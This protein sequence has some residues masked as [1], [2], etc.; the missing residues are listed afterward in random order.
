MPND[1]QTILTQGSSS[2]TGATANNGRVV[3]ASQTNRPTAAA[4]PLLD[5]LTARLTQQ[6]K[7]ITSS[8]TSNLQTSMNDAIAST[9]LGGDLRYQQLESERSR[10]MGFARDRAGATYTG[11]LESRTGYATQVAGL[12]ELT[13][14][15]EKSIRDLDKRYQEAILANDSAT[16]TRVAD[17]QVKKLEFQQK[18]EENFF[19]NLMG[20]ANMQEQA[21]SRAQQNEQFWQKSEQDQQQF[22]MN[23]A[24]S[25]V[26]F[27]KNYGLN[28]KEMG[29][30]EQQLELERSKYN[31]SV[32]EY[33]DRKKAL[34]NDKNSMN[35]QAMIA[36]DIKTKLQAGGFDKQT[37]LTPD[38]IQFVQDRT[39]F[40]GSTE[41]L[42]TLITSA[43]GSVSMDTG[44]MNSLNSP[45][46]TTPSSTTG[47]SRDW[48]RIS[49][50]LGNMDQESWSLNPFGNTLKMTSMATKG[51]YNY[52]TNPI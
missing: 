4:N 13:E 33:N 24:N 27:E 37:L 28:L 25:N 45:A 9:Q 30:K 15:T 6:A 14:T 51:T 29:L 34:I 50:R 35:T 46:S 11:A 49:N 3:A 22:V 38:Y 40:K 32:S 23:M 5:A 43:Y 10:E 41:E 21:I 16:A 7:G 2:A 18:Q 17:L 39:G 12:R 31:L 44:F 52:F 47:A 8:S 36:N 20:V 1:L 42:A 19:N 26:Q 48:G